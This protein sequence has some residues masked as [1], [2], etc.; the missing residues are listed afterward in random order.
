MLLR[1]QHGNQDQVDQI[2][3][4]KNGSQKHTKHCAELTRLLV[5]C[6]DKKVDIPN[7]EDYV[8][9]KNREEVFVFCNQVS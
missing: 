6:S 9:D 4:G 8:Q 1:N 2:C 7:E 3:T 5:C